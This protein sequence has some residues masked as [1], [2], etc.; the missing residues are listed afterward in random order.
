VQGVYEPVAKLRL[1]TDERTALV[2]FACVHLRP[3]VTALAIRSYSAGRAVI[4]PSVM[5]VIVS[6][7]SVSKSSGSW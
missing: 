7:A 3:M 2:I 4:V 1:D 6:L 5:P